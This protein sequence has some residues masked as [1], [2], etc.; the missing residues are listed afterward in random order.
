MMRAKKLFGGLMAVCM[1]LASVFIYEPT[2]EIGIG[3]TVSAATYPEG[4]TVDTTIKNGACYRIKNV[5]TGMYLDAKDGT[6]T[7]GTATFVQQNDI[8]ASN[9][10]IFKFISAG[11]DCYYLVSTLGDG[12]KFVMDVNGG[13]P[14]SGANI[15]LWEYNKGD[16]QKFRFMKH[17]EFGT[18]IIN[19]KLTNNQKCIEVKD[20]SNN[21]GVGAEIVQADIVCDGWQQWALEP[22]YDPGCTMDESLLYT[23]KNKKT[24]KVIDIQ[25]GTIADDTNIVAATDTGADNQKWHLFKNNFNEYYLLNHKDDTFGLYLVRHES[26]VSAVL[27]KKR[28]M[29]QNNA[30]QEPGM[31]VKFSK[32]LDGTYRLLTQP[33]EYNSYLEENSSGDICDNPQYLTDDSQLWNVLSEPMPAETTPVTTTATTTTTTTKATTTTTTTT[34][35]TVTSANTTASTT[36]TTSQTSEKATTVSSKETA[37]QT[38]LQTT[39]TEISS[40]KAETTST[41]AS[42]TSTKANTTLTE[43]ETLPETVISTTVE[44]TVSETETSATPEEATTVT[45]QTTKATKT[46]KTTEKPTEAVTTA[47]TTTTEP[48]QLDPMK[49][50]RGDVDVNGIVDFA[51]VIK[52]SMY[53]LNKSSYPLDC[54]EAEINADVTY[55]GLITLLDLSKLIEYNLGQISADEL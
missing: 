12:G 46:S 11:D 29:H 47:T 40:T 45:S 54:K 53:L 35:T 22:I 25:S 41:E 42:S 2:S 6:V 38:T 27:K 17:D 10:N 7:E 8:D 13:N 32:N 55:D 23:F 52:L 16:N 50:M 34:T 51:D 33:S 31:W 36:S 37:L 39:K 30:Y 3:E 21:I 20:K 14:N 15:I 4:F 18:Y 19:T 5:K 49:L 1:T 43:E 24:G 48:V 44:T 26:P 28:D 9:R